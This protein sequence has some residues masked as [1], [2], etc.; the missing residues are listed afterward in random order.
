M[1]V[2][3]CLVTG[4][5][6]GIGRATAH[7]LAVR[8]LR[9]VMACRDLDSARALE[10]ELIDATGNR[11]VHVLGCD[12]ASLSAVRHAAAEFA[13]R[14]GELHLLINNAGTMLTRHRLSEDGYE[15]TFAVNYLGPYLLTRLLLPRLMAA[16]RA[17]IVNVASQMHVS[18]AID[19]E[20]LTDEPDS[21]RYHGMQA[22]SD[23]KLGNVMFTL[24]LAE[25]L[26]ADVVTANC[27]HPGVVATN[28]MGATNA[29]LR[30]GM[31]I[32]TPFMRSPTKGA[33]PTL[34]V[35]LDEALTGVTG[36]YFDERLRM[37][38]PAQAA[39]DRAGRD[40]L[41]RWSASACGVSEECGVEE[42][43]T[44]Q[45]DVQEQGAQ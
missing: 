24:S 26:P 14:F 22:Y 23:S 13:D 7:A 20:S 17:R 5:T 3:T 36:R 6:H 31:R 37:V 27:L 11:E 9:L 29:L 35:A 40:A 8:G 18:G 44:V 28:I 34:Q 43:S 4:T 32:A 10:A 42:D 2:K 33:G 21:R 30:V 15:L 45:D 1:S 25:R 38:Q 39:L 19:V 41:W 12:L 16:G